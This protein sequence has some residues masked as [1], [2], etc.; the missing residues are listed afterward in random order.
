MPSRRPTR[1][2]D[3]LRVVVS[4]RV[5]ELTDRGERR[6]ALDQAWTSLLATVGAV[7]IP[8]PNGA[9][10]VTA[11]IKAVSPE[12]LVL[13]GGG[14]LSPTMRQHSG[15]PATVPADLDDVAR[16]RDET[17]RA[18]LIAAEAGGWPVLGVCRGMQA[19][20]AYHGGSLTALTGHAGTRHAIYNGF[21]GLGDVLRGEQVVNSFHDL[22]VMPEGLPSDMEALSHAPDGSVEAVRHRTLPH[23]GLMWHPER[24]NPFAARDVLLLKFILYNGTLQ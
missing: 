22:G 24:E 18:L 9:E 8:V 16:E 2:P 17:E 3:A 12:A 15:A 21:S 6:D 19:L 4:Q 5:M 11:F 23:F 1:H 7:C 20:I 13:S 10:S 14:N